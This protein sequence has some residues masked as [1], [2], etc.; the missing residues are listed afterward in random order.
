M[1][2]YDVEG[3]LHNKSQDG[4]CLKRKQ[5]NSFIIH[6]IAIIVVPNVML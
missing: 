2:D 6:T 5:Q 4:R 3:G 1:V